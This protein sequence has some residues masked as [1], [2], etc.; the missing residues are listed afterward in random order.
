MKL[1]RVMLAAFMVSLLAPAA[2]AQR[3]DRHVFSDDAQSLYRRSAFAHG[4]IHGYE[5]GFHCANLD[6]HMG[7]SRRD[8][9]HELHVAKVDRRRILYQESYGDKKTFMKGYEQGYQEAYNDVFDGK[10]FRAVNEARAAAA[11]LSGPGSP[12]RNFDDG[13]VAGITAA[14]GGQT[15]LVR[16]V[17]T[18]NEWC[19]QNVQ[20]AKG[21]YCNGYARGVIFA[22]GATP[23]LATQTTT[24]RS[25]VK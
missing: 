18:T 21:D 19:I 3:T 24:A 1:P 20:N 14:H 17:N 5:E 6:W 9:G 2:I 23:S 8:I 16:D 4:Y 15:M 22:S 12:D 7:R 11:G 25:F 13:F 10:P